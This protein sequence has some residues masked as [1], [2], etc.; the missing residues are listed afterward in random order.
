MALRTRIAPALLL[1]ALWGIPSA[2]AQEVVDGIAARVENDVILRS[3]LR[4]LA[5]YQ[6][7]VDGKREPDAQLLERLIDQWIVHVEADASRF[8]R[9]ASA[10][11]DRELDRLKNGYASAA[12]FDRR[13]AQASLSETG[14]RRILEEQLYLSS[15]LDSRFR[16][17][18]QVENAA[19][20]EYYEK[21]VVPLTQKKGETPPALESS[22]EMIRE[23]LI[24]RG[25]NEQSDRWLKERRARLHIEKEIS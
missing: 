8:K 3:D 1:L 17:A 11:V 6:Q 16:P 24:Q 13:R 9:P 18:V 19:V 12:E 21:N 4:E 5:A 10:D 15:Y 2:R 20:E 14:L 7:L 23:L 25:I 22:R